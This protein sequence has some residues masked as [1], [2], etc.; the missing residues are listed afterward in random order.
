MTGEPLEG[1]HSFCVD[2]GKVAAKIAKSASVNVNS[3]ALRDE[4]KAVVRQY[5]HQGR[6]LLVASGVDV[7]QLDRDL[8]RLR[9]LAEGRNALASYRRPLATVRKALPGLTTSLEMQAAAGSGEGAATTAEKAFAEAVGALVPTAGLSYQQAIRD[10]ADSGRTSYRGTATELRE[11]LREVLDHLAP[12]AD[13]VASPGFKL[14]DGV[15]RPTMKQKVRFIL[16]A[17]DQGDTTRA[18]SER[19]A[20]A[21]ET[22]VGGLTR[23][24]YD[25]GSLVTH[26]AGERQT[27]VHLKRYVEAVLSHL[28]EL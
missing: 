16:K 5:L 14:E 18:M 26:V 25:Y 21:V 4:L 17:R 20:E 22:M 28:L 6:P 11:V 2:F 3:T 19:A 7:T 23:S 13:V 15:K 27:V 1:W 24:V 8:Q 10:L 9:E 12:D